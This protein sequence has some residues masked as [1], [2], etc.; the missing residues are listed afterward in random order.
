ML[1]DTIATIAAILLAIPLLVLGIEC[2]LSL[3]PLRRCSFCPSD[4]PLRTV[5]VIPAHNEELCIATTVASV[6]RQVKSPAS[7]IVVADN[8]DDATAERAI[9]SG[10]T[11][12]S[13][14]DAIHRGKGYALNFA[15]EQLAQSPPDIVIFIDADCTP[16]PNCIET[17]SQ[18]AHYHQRPVQAADIILAPKT[19]TAISRV[20][21]LAVYVKNIARPRGLQW[22]GMPCMLNGTGMAFPWSVLTKVRFSNE[23]IAEDARIC[24]DLVMAGI[25]PLPCME[26]HVSSLLAE[27]NTGFMSQRTRWE[28]GHL[29]MIFSHA[30]RLL[31]AIIKRPTTSLLA[32]LLEVSVPPLSLLVALSVICTLAFAVTSYG[33]G[34]WLPLMCYLA[35][36]SLAAGGLAAVWLRNGREILSPRMVLQIPKYALV[37]AP[38]YLR[39]VTRRQ[40]EWV[41]TER[42]ISSVDDQAGR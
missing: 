7:V 12:W 39:F 38:M 15:V 40:R 5:V 28:H 6:H 19:G 21:A 16:G 9:R 13:R 17:I 2:W 29:S 20:S 27:H 36:G 37:K 31:L 34:S 42:S 22:L 25:A 35:I 10:A 3:L 1:T 26:V 23:E 11:V 8:C 32:I 4:S 33:I 18:L 14:T 41:R 30:P 24:L